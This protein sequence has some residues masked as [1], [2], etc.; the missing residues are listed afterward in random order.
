MTGHTERSL[1]GGSLPFLLPKR[2]A[3]SAFR[4]YTIIKQ[5]PT[6]AS[7]RTSA[8]NTSP[9]RCFP[10]HLRSK[11]P[12]DASPRTSA[13]KH[14]SHSMLPLAPPLQALVPFDASPI[15]SGSH[16]CV[17]VNPSAYLMPPPFPSLSPTP[18]PSPPPPPLYHHQHHHRA[19]TITTTP[20]TD[21]W[22][23]SWVGLTTQAACRLSFDVQISG[24]TCGTTL[25]SLPKLLRVPSNRKFVGLSSFHALSSY[26]SAASSSV[27]K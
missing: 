22:P 14:Q 12:T 11:H 24:R 3:Q 25:P 27:S 16:S 23:A 21:V 13:P 8:P 20:T 15:S 5:V 2:P 4:P 6:D 10:S 18:S 17:I 1:N 26:A 7:P 19:A 9:F